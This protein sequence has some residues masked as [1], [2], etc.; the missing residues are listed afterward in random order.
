LRHLASFIMPAVPEL[1]QTYE[2]AKAITDMY[3]GENDR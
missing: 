1:E 2:E 3:N